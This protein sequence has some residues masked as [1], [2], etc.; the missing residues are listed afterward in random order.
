MTYEG[1]LSI[2][3]SKRPTNFQFK[4]NPAFLVLLV[5]IQLVHLSSY[6]ASLSW[7]GK[8]LSST[9]W[10][11]VSINLLLVWQVT[12]LNEMDELNICKRRYRITKTCCSSSSSARASSR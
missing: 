8:A 7:P 6:L 11:L 3:L 4:Y 2:F 12:V 1:H 9:D 5:L 10:R